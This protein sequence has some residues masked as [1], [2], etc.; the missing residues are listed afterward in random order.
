VTPAPPATPPPPAASALPAAPWSGFSGQVTLDVKSLVY[1]RTTEISG[2]TGRMTIDPQRLAAEQITGKL[3]T[4]GQL[5]LNT[6]VRFAAGEPQPYASKFDLNV[7]DFEVGPLFKA[8]SPGKPPTVEGRFNIRSQ[9]TG[10]GRTLGELIQHTRGEFVLQSRKGVFRGLQQEAAA[11]SL[12]ARLLG[13]LGEKVENLATRADVTAEIAGQL[14][15]LQF[16]QLNVRL[17]RDQSLNLKLTDFVLVSPNVRLQ[18]DGL[19]TYDPTKS[20]LNQAM[21]VRI[22]MGVMGAVETKISRAK[23]PVLSGER[24]DL[25]YMKLREPFV[26]GGT[27]NKPNAS[28][29]YVM[30]T[31]SL[32][33][34][35][36]P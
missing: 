26:I 19:I 35:L 17:S 10:T 11:V 2:L 27:L 5:L 6:E 1:G 13:S 14:A 31:R 20:L 15:Q 8:M 28:Q 12:A 9:A 23:L 22:N 4:D 33:D 34:L 21:Q 36:L 30:L 25:G 29:L 24:D 18:G 16:D 7:R 32:L 3:G